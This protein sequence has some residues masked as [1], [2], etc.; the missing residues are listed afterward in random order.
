MVKRVTFPYTDSLPS[1]RSSGAAMAAVLKLV[2]LLAL[3]MAV[4]G[5]GTKNELGVKENS[6]HA[7]KWANT[8]REN[9]Y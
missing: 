3:G 7:G 5:K 1:D 6:E 9:L 8:L 2:C 4:Q